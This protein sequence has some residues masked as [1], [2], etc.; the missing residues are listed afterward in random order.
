MSTG[1]AYGSGIYLAKDSGTS[2][3]YAKMGNG[4]PKSMLGSVNLQC[5]SLC[6][7]T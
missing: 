4:W 1:Q 7:R 3:G 2:L 5:L 6:E